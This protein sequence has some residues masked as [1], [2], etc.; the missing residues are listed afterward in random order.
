VVGRAAWAFGLVV[1]FDDVFG[2]STWK[3]WVTG[4]ETRLRVAV[5]VAVASRR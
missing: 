5:D 3:A 1:V 4:A 2:A